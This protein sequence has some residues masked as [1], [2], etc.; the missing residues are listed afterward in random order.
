MRAAVAMLACAAL[1]AG[2]ATA[3]AAHPKKNAHFSGSFTFAGING[4]KPAVSFDVS[5]DGKTVT[6]FTFQTLG[7]FGAGGFRKGVNYYAKPEA[8]IHVAGSLK[9]SSSGHFSATGVV[10]KYTAF[11]QTTTTTTTLSATFTKAKAAT[12]TVSFSQSVAQVGA[13]C[14]PTQALAFKA[15]A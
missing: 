3:L 6:H 2:A 14:G 12:G 11:G 5:K 15:K 13:S 10:W 9:I 1:L 4:F 7:C 8:I